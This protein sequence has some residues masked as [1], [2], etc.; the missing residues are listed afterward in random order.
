MCGIEY[1]IKQLL[2]NIILPIMHLIAKST[3]LK[4]KCLQL[5]DMFPRVK[6]R[7]KTAYAF[8]YSHELF[9]CNAYETYDKL[10]PKAKYIYKELHGKGEE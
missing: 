7:L 4:K 6:K 2:K 9:A 1:F 3:F 10:T 5:G 8:R